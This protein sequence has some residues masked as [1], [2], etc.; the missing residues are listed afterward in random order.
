M[1]LHEKDGKKYFDAINE[2]VKHS[3]DWF[4]HVGSKRAT[5]KRND[6]SIKTVAKLLYC[7]I[8]TVKIYVKFKLLKCDV[9]D[10]KYYFLYEWLED[11][12]NDDRYIDA[13]GNI[14]ERTGYDS[15][16]YTDKTGRIIV[17]PIIKWIDARGIETD[18][19]K[20]KS[21][22][23]RYVQLVCVHG[24]KN[25]HSKGVGGR[26]QG[27]YLKPTDEDIALM[28]KY[29]LKIGDEYETLYST[30]SHNADVN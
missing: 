8:Y 18:K 25:R 2:G 4:L 5:R 11:F 23:V 14:P 1:V 9:I 15:P 30:S 10:N 27:Y 22:P 16:F 29:N 13:N 12:A 3:R 19:P 7:D 17:T 21:P 28:K 24:D 26:A 6:I 20:S